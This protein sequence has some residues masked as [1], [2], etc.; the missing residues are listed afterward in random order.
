MPRLPKTPV[1]SLW[2]KHLTIKYEVVTSLDAPWSER[3]CPIKRSKGWYCLMK[4]G[5]FRFR[6][7][8]GSSQ[9]SGAPA[10][11]ETFGIH[12]FNIVFKLATIFYVG[13]HIRSWRPSKMIS[14]P[15]E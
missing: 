12:S 14:R 5:A 2:N 1:D 3:V 8:S 7:A 15:I 10:A 13:S 9:A 6:V 11:R 4:L